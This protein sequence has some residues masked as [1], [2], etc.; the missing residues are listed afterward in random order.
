MCQVGEEG[1]LRANSYRCRIE[2]K[3]GEEEQVWKGTTKY[4]KWLNTTELEKYKDGNVRHT[5]K[6]KKKNTK[7]KRKKN[8]KKGK[9]GKKGKKR[10]LSETGGTT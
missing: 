2:F 10:R 5:A 8:G 4:M 3:D 9:G 1:G 7:K 6:K